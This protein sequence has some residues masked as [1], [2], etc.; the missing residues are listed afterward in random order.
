MARI[1]HGYGSEWHLLRYLGRHRNALNQAIEQETGGRVVDWLDFG[2]D[3]SRFLDSELKGL[4]FLT[5]DSYADVKRAWAAFWPQTGNVPNWD[6]VGWLTFGSN[7]ELLLVEAKA[8]AE[9]LRSACAAKPHGGRD[10]ICRAFESTISAFGLAAKVD[11]W[12]EPYYQ[13]CNRLAALHFLREHN[14][15]ARLLFI[16]FYG[17]TNMRGRH[18]PDCPDEWQ[19]RVLPELYERIKFSPYDQKGSGVHNVYLPV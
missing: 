11:D 4:N 10:M 14:V 18:C 12:L 19:G 13:Y 16:Y 3:R 1:G 2:F 7:M 6:A 5:A 17:E 8:H 9:E 15:P